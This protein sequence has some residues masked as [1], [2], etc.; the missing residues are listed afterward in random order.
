MSGS[1]NTQGINQYQSTGLMG[2]GSYLDQLQATTNYDDQLTVPSRYSTME[3]WKVFDPQGYQDAVSI[4]QNQDQ[5][6]QEKDYWLTGDTYVPVISETTDFLGSALWGAIEGIS[7]GA[8]TVAD[9]ASG[10]ELSDKF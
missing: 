8:G 7:F 1:N 2:G 6:A 3:E 10:G 9:I 4:L 5:Q